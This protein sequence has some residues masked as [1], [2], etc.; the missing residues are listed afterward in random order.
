MELLLSP[1]ILL[2]SFG[3]IKADDGEQRRFISD[4]SGDVLELYDARNRLLRRVHIENCEYRI[5]SIEYFEHGRE[6]VITLELGDYR[7]IDGMFAPAE[8]RIVN[9]LDGDKT[10]TFEIILKSIKSADTIKSSVFAKPDTRGFKDVYRMVNGKAVEQS[11][12]K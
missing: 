2:E 1:K 8:I 4:K 5:S 3:I 9:H 7:D 6:R 11:G 12:P 10:E